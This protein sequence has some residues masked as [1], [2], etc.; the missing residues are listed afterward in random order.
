MFVYRI[1]KVNFSKDLSGT[2]AGLFG[3]RWN[4]KGIQLVYTASSISLATLEYLVHNFHLMQSQD[5]CLTKIQITKPRSIEEIS[6]GNLP[7]DWNEK[8]YLPVSS[9]QIGLD[10]FTSKKHYILKVPSAIV[11]GEFNYLLNPFHP[12][13]SSTE[14]KE[15]VFPFSIDKRLFSL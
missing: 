8:S 11:P 9:Q 4:P 13:H 15:Q 3:G 1:C 14:I 7:S 6:T 5:L 2:G 12:Y 10:F